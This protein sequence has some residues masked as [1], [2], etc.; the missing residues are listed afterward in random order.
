[1]T[2]Q[3]LQSKIEKIQSLGCKLSVEE[4][5]ATILKKEAKSNKNSK[6]WKRRDSQKVASVQLDAKLSKMTIGEQNQYF[7]DVRIKSLLG[8]LPSSMR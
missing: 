2:T 4:I 1:M 8:Q 7:E 6:S 3:E 5:T